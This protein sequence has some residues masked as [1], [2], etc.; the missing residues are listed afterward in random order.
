MI[1]NPPSRYM[2]IN[3]AV[4]PSTPNWE[5]PAI[6]Q[7]IFILHLMY[8]YSADIDKASPSFVDSTNIFIHEGYRT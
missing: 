8:K 1:I 3:G 2:T 7:H 4:N 5:L 6:N